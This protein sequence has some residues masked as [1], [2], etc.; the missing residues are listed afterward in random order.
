MW[1][2]E[3]QSAFENLKRVL[4]TALVL[5]FPQFH[6]PFLLEID[7]SSTGLG[8]VLAQ[9]QDDGTVRP[10]TYPSRSFLAGWEKA[11]QE[12]DLEIHY[13]A[14]KTNA[15]ADALSRAPLREPGVNES[16]SIVAAVSVE[17]TEEAVCCKP[18]RK[19]L[20]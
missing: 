2:P 11:L 4:T 5:V 20:I 12:L 14:G 13:R 19:M 1:T 16:F 18:S 6:R 17:D 7:A 10:V 9:C 8:A 15:N 3:C